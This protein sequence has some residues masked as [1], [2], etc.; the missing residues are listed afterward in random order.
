MTAPFAAE[1]AISPVDG[2]VVYVVVDVD[3][4]VHAE[5]TEF[6]AWL[7]R[8]DRSPNTERVNAGRV[9]RYLSFCD[10]NSL[11]WNAVTIDDLGRFLLQHCQ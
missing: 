10:R 9:A 1:R 4:V 6:L 7:R 3:F 8:M 5:A 11:L 2:S